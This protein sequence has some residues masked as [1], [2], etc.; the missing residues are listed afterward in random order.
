MEEN[1]LFQIAVSDYVFM[2]KCQVVG[3]SFM[4]ENKLLVELVAM[5]LI[6]LSLHNKPSVC[7]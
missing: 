7:V 1:K 3:E 5:V 6:F 4:L 2:P